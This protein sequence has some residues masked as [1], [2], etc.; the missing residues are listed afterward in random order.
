MEGDIVGTADGQIVGRDVGNVKV[1]VK[2][3]EGSNEGCRVGVSDGISVGD[4]FL[5]INGVGVNNWFEIV[6]LPT[7]VGMFIDNTLMTQMFEKTAVK[8]WQKLDMDS[9]K[10]RETTR[11]W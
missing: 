8:M 5:S 4:K 6:N 3:S 7:I 10:S 2:L 11:D 1:G 9:R